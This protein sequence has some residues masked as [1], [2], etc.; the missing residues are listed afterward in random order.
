MTNSNHTPNGQPAPQQPTTVYQAPSHTSRKGAKSG[1]PKKPFWK[2]WWFWL[3]VVIIVVACSRGTGDSSPNQSSS[4]AASSSSSAAAPTTQSSPEKTQRT[5]DATKTTESPKNEE[6]NEPS[7][8]TA[9]QVC[10][11]AAKQQ[12]F[13]GMAYDSDAIL[14]QQKWQQGLDKNQWLA[15]YNVKVGPSKIKTAVTCL[16]DTSSSPYKVISVNQTEWR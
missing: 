3:I 7:Y 6:S 11:E 14:G 2:K 8:G 10:D 12:V 16:V 4:T 5:Q 13:P 1:K 9:V 15:T